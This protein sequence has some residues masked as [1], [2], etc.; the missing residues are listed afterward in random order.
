MKFKDIESNDT[1]TITLRISGYSNIHFKNDEVHVYE[2]ETE[3]HII[4]RTPSK[5][6]SEIYN[7]TYN[8]FKIKVI[9]YDYEGVPI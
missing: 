1:I 5:S 8:N 9:L 3:N 6:V 7:I 4:W 2:F